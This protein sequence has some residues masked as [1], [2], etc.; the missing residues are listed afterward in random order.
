M[1]R[2]FSLISTVIALLCIASCSTTKYVADGDY[3]LDD[4][5]VKCDDPEIDAT[6]LYDYMIQ[7]PNTPGTFF[8]KTSLRFYSLSGRDTSKWINKLIRRFGEPPVIYS[9]EYTQLSAKEIKSQL[10]NMGYFTAD[11]NYDVN[12]KGK[13]ASVVYD[14]KAGEPYKIHNV[15]ETID[16]G[17]IDDILHSKN[18]IS[19]DKV[20][21]GAIYNAE[22][23]D[24]RVGDIVSFVR[25][26]GYYNFTKENLYYSV[27]STLGTHQVDLKLNLHVDTSRVGHPL[28][29]YRTSKVMVTMGD[30]RGYS[31]EY[32]GVSDTTQYKRLTIIFPKGRRFLRPSTIYNNT[33]VREGRLYSELLH[34]RTFSALS[35]L[36]AVQTANVTYTPDTAPGSLIA[37]ISVSP[38][39]P[40]Y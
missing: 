39:K 24:S 20:K 30:Y 22:N 34:D 37:N 8:N 29:R 4:I 40:Y 15:D 1:K 3:L 27:D 23:I 12:K 16:G 2:L 35:G 5:N 19:N 7:Q 11:V 31:G 28:T 33:F 10:F 9:E 14:I 25:N 32:T 13:K 38:A 18:F 17:L 21:E 6:D 26:Q 36:S